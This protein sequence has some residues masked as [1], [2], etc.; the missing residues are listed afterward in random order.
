MKKI[1]L[2]ALVLFALCAC[3]EIGTTNVYNKN[4]TMAKS[5]S[6][7]IYLSFSDNK[8]SSFYFLLSRDTKFKDYQLHVRW[9]SPQR[10]ELVFN[11]TASTL[12]FLIDGTKI[13][14]FHPMKR[15]KIVAYNLDKSGHEEEGIFL[16]TEEEL[17]QITYSKDVTA[18]LTGKYVT[19]VGKFNRRN[20]MKAFRDFMENSH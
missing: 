1:T 9:H 3:S 4:L 11:D 20:T 15:P 13:L 10:G 14:T 8:N 17:R 19:V 12:K 16:L 2:F 5:T 6:K 18:E 7:P